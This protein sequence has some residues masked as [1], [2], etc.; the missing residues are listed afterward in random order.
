LKARVLANLKLHRNNKGVKGVAVIAIEV[1]LSP[2]E[3]FEQIIIITSIWIAA[4]RALKM[5]QLL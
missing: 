3:G 1:R 4:A 2:A 5:V